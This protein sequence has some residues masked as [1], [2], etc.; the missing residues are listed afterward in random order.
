MMELALNPE[1]K[2]YL[3]ATHSRHG[4]IQFVFMFPNNY[5]ASVVSH[6]YSYG[7]G[8]G[9]WEIAVLDENESLCY[10]TEVTDDVIGYLEEDEVLD[11]LY[12][13]FRLEKKRTRLK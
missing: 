7:G 1:L 5:G 13:I 4:G 12:H 11:V 10:S 3:K 8:E 2:N 9:L 6:D